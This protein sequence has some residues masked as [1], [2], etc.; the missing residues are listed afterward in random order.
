MLF[1]PAAKALPKELLP[2]LDTP[3]IQ[4][5]IQEA[6]AAGFARMIFASHPSKSAIE[7]HVP[8][9]KH[10]REAGRTCRVRD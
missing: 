6:R 4:H 10:V 8:D 7:R 2:G 1:L 9:D 3:P 5:T